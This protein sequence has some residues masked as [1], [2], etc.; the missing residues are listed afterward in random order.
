[1]LKQI[2]CKYCRQP[3][4]SDHSEGKG[5]PKP[6]IVFCSQEC[7][8]NYNKYVNKKENVCKECGKS[9]S[10]VMYM[11]GKLDRNQFCSKECY[12]TNYEREKRYIPPA[13]VC[14]Y[15][16]G[17][18]KPRR[19]QS[20]Q[21]WTPT[22]C[23]NE[24][25]EAYMKE[26]YPY[27]E[28]TENICVVCGKKFYHKTNP[29]TRKAVKVK[30]CS[31]DCYRKG[32]IENRKETFIKNY[33]VEHPFKLQEIVDKWRDTNIEK[34]GTPYPLLKYIS[35]H[36]QEIV[37]E[38]NLHFA[39]ILEKE[40]IKYQ[41]ELMLSDDNQKLVRFYDF[42]LPDY[43]LLIEINPTYT[44]STIKPK[45]LDGVKGKTK[46]YHKNKVDLA[47]S[48]GFNC[49]CIWDWTDVPELIK[50]IKHSNY[51]IQ[52]RDIQK[53]WNK[54]NRKEYIIDN[55]FNESD[56]I[57]QGYLPLFDDGQDI[58]IGKEK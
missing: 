50:A 19:K 12:R 39:E 13:G 56:M 32:F 42:Y 17:I 52:K 43:N 34:Y 38:N 58:I 5:V 6:K 49:I 40:D 7:C 18:V 41:T 57:N 16:H 1:M 8:D 10:A 21:Y 15:C 33:G 31:T 30:Y 27:Q 26:L 54:D 25:Y 23:C 46:E 28:Q 3:F 14:K 47:N 53:I 24:H 4:M 20:G 22:F 11:T 35:E 37:S 45:G 36:K 44:H 29:K 51:V 2:K 48:F 9:F 55:N